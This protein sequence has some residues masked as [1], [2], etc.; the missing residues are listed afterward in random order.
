MQLY[1]VVCGMRITKVARTHSWGVKT[2]NIFPKWTEMCEFHH[3]KKS[4][5]Y[6][7]IPMMEMFHVLQTRA[8][9][10]KDDL[11]ISIRRKEHKHSAPAINIASA[12]EH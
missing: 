9:L 7:A 8:A 4:K 1:C 2:N 10:P 12:V 5:E 11:T 6:D 3:C